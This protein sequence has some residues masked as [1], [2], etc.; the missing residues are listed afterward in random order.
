M[1]SGALATRSFVSSSER[2]FEKEIFIAIER[3]FI[4]MKCSTATIST[5]YRTQFYQTMFIC[6]RICFRL[7]L[8]CSYSL[9][10]KAALAIPW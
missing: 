2:N 9:M 7:T 5:P 3:I 10:T 1:T 6:T 8:L 4:Q